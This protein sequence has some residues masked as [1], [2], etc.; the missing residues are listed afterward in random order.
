MCQKK[1]DTVRL[2]LTFK[3]ENETFL[4]CEDSDGNRRSFRKIDISYLID[5]KRNKATVVVDRKRLARI[6]KRQS[7]TAPMVISK[8]KAKTRKCLNCKSEFKAE[9]NIF[10]CTPC[11]KTSNWKSGGDYSLAA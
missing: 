6:M 1:L 7:V 11:K 3:R 8:A 10:I 4:I 5:K 9:P 2:N